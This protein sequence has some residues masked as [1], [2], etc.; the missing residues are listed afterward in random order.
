MHKILSIYLAKIFLRIMIIISLVGI[1]LLLLSGIIDNFIKQ[2]TNI[3]PA[4]V[5]FRLVV[6]KIPY[7]FQEI[8][9]FI[10]LISGLIFHERLII[11][12]EYI[13]MQNF[14]LSRFK[15]LSPILLTIF[16]IG[17]LFS[18][19][20]NPL[21]ASLLAKHEKLESQYLGIRHNVATLS[22]KGIIAKESLGDEI[23]IVTAEKLSKSDN[24]L[25]NVS[26]FIIN[27]QHDDFGN[28]IKRLYAK[29][30]YCF[31]NKWELRDGFDQQKLENFTNYDIHTRLTFKDLEESF[32]SPEIISFWRLPGFI[33]RMHDSGLS[34]IKYLNYYFKLLLR[35]LMLVVL[36][37]F[38]SSFISLN[39]RTNYQSFLIVMGLVSGFMLYFFSFILTSFL[40][41][42]SV[43]SFF[44]SLIPIIVIFAISCI[45]KI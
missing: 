35:P 9:P 2:D 31:A 44:A 14:G 43:H 21:A 36:V 41:A 40:T 1:F 37:I 29:K 38:A 4:G 33:N 42:Q 10:V 6:I 25:T 15:I 39:S 27:F 18:L 13:A 23:R 16:L 12:N 32:S 7:L 34:T 19:I 24:S 17:I 26:I 45:I 20:L 5:F 8:L 11:S 30:A 22:N 28:N 3:V